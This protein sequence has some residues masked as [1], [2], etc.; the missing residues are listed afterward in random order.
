MGH[1]QPKVIYS[2][3]KTTRENSIIRYIANRVLRNNKNML[4]ALT[5]QVGSGKSWSGLS[6]CEMYSKLTGI[7][8]DPSVHVISS[9][10]ELLKLI[11]SKDVDKNVRVGTAILFDEPQVEANSRAWQS[12]VN[13][14]FNALMST[15]RNQRL[16][17]FFALP[18]LEM[19]DKQS[20]ILFMG[21][22]RVE[23]FDRNTKITTIKP[24]FLEWNKSKEEFYRKRLIIEFAVEGKVKRNSIKL[25]N[26]HIPKPS[27]SVVEVYEAIKKKFSDD[28]NKK[29][30]ERIELKE[31]VNE[32]KNKNEEFLKIKELYDKYGEDYLTIFEEM[33]H[34]NP[35][36]IQK[37]VWFIKKSKKHIF[38]R[39]KTEKMI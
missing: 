16:V 33:P 6:M 5:G 30:L 22:F 4:V 19:I 20:R 12:E 8:F 21:E 39:Q 26:W 32:G 23:G 27:D 17:V 2:N 9:L 10:K 1:F 31:K 34:L 35:T 38:E 7:P 11:T 18:Y 15:F 37:Y 29:L 14:A 13:Q 24:R 36:T 28:L 3:P 25:H